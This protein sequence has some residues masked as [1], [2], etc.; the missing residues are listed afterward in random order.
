MARAPVTGQMNDLNSRIDK[1]E[2]ERDAMAIALR[3]S[4]SER[5]QV[6]SQLATAKAD[7]TAAKQRADKLDEMVRVQQKAAN[8]AVEGLRRQ[9]AILIGSFAAL[10]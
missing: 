10:S 7:A 1:I 3:D 2:R 9:P 6:L 4:R 5:Q 8:Q